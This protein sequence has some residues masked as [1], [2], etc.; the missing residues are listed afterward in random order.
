MI[1]A[2]QTAPTHFVEANDIGFAY[3]PQQQ[4]GE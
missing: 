2:Q 4:R 3:P 1:H